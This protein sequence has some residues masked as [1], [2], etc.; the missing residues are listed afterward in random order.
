MQAYEG[1]VENGRFYPTGLLARVTGRQ[2]A[3][4]TVLDESMEITAEN[5]D[6]TFWAEFNSLIAQS[7]N[8]ELR[9]EDF[10]RM[11]LGREIVDFFEEKESS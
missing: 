1:Y 7:A 8:E 4:L 5:D 3:I 2:R 9:E 6:K 10:P 11:R